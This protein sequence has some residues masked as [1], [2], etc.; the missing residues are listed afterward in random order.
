LARRLFTFSSAI[1]Y[2]ALHEGQEIFT[3][4]LLSTYP[5]PGRAR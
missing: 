1:E 3:L 2:L 5:A 4:H